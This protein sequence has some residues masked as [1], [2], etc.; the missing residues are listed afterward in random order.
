MKILTGYSDLAAAFAEPG[1][2]VVK[3]IDWATRFV[4]PYH[5]HIVQVPQCVVRRVCTTTYS[6]IALPHHKFLINSLPLHPFSSVPL[7]NLFR[8][9]FDQISQQ[10]L[11]YPIAV[12][13]IA[14]VSN[15][16]HYPNA[17]VISDHVIT[18]S[19]I[20]LFGMISL[21]TVYDLVLDEGDNYILN[22]TVR[23]L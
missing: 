15:N 10:Q 3:G 20:T 18:F 14:E 4:R 16:P 23:V 6:S 21:P 22:N 19:R 12:A 17:G 13:P 11:Q 5:C 7:A 1:E 8:V 2:Y 9:R